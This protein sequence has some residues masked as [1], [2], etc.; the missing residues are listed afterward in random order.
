MNFWAL[1]YGLKPQL[2]EILVFNLLSARLFSLIISSLFY[3]YICIQLYKN[4]STKQ[5]ILSIVQI[6]LVTFTF[7]TRM[8]ER[9]TF[10][11]LIPIFILSIS[12]RKFL[13]FFIL[14]SLTHMINIYHW[15]WFPH[16]NFLVNLFEQEIIVRLVSLTNVILTLV[17]VFT[18]PFHV[19][20][21]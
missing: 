17:L 3:I 7:M 2:D 15:W 18:K 4:Y 16:I 12:D 5:L 6:T 20:K 14:L 21:Y 9:Y 13:K 10:P 8:H 11:S 1:F 19:R